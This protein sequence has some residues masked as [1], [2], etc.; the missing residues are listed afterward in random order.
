MRW[1]Q[2]TQLGSKEPVA[3]VRQSQACWVR[4]E[5]RQ[6]CWVQCEPRQACWVR[7]KRRQACWV[8]RSVGFSICQV[9]I[10]SF[11]W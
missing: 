7:C 6:A 4:C 5:P 1:V 8:L 2:R 3:W 10:S 9:H 11:P